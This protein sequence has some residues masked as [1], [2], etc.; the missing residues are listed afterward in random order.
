MAMLR[1]SGRRQLPDAIDGFF[2]EGVPLKLFVRERERIESRDLST[3]RVE[4]FFGVLTVRFQ[5][6]EAGGGV[7]RDSTLRGG[8]FATP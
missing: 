5:S 8:F 7:R 4:V 3:Q 1:T 6:L 2:G